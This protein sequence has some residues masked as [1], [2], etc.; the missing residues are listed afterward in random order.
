M[1]EKTKRVNRA[2]IEELKKFA[3]EIRAQ[4]GFSPDNWEQIKD[5]AITQH[6]KNLKEGN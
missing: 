6:R 4:T 1:P 3:D 5:E 2:T